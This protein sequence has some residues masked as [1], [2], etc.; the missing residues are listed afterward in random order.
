MKTFS[1]V[2]KIV[3]LTAIMMSAVTFHANADDLSVN[4]RDFQKVTVSGAI[5]VSYAQAPTYL[6]VARGD[7]RSLES[8]DIRVSGKTLIIGRRSG[9]RRSGEVKVEVMAPEVS[10]FSLSGASHLLLGETELPSIS[11]QL[12]GA[13]TMKGSL[14]AKSLTVGCSG[15]SNVKANVQCEVVKLS[16]SGASGVELKGNSGVVSGSCSGASHVQLNG[17]STSANV[18]CSGAS[19]LDL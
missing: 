9:I 15:A 19:H 2:G 8:L 4:V 1:F 7:Q 12:S 3:A 10:D 6:V 14:K 13:S 11:V 17:S 16:C 5:S 18:N